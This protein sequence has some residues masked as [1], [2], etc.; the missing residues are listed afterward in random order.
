MFRGMDP[1]TAIPRAI[2]TTC[3]SCPSK[4]LV[5]VLDLGDM[6]LANQL[7]QTGDDPAAQRRYPLEL[8][9]CS[10]CSTIQ[11]AARVAPEKMFSGYCY[12]SSYSDTMVRHAKALAEQVTSRQSLGPESLVIEAGSNDGYL[13]QW[14]RQMGIG[15]LGVEPAAS[16]AHL[17]KTERNI[18]TL[19]AY[20]GE[21]VARE[22]RSE[23]QLADVFH[24][25]NVMAHVP[26]QR[27]FIK[28]I[29][30]VLKENG[31][32]IIEVP[33]VVDM[34]EQLEFD[35]IYHEHVCYFSLSSLSQAFARQ[36]MRVVDVERLPIHGGSLRVTAAHRDS[37]HPTNLRVGRLLAWERTHRVDQFEYYS[38]F[39]GRVCKLREDLRSLLHSLKGQGKRLAAYGA[40]AKGAMLLNHCGIDDSILDFVVD[41]NPIKH[42]CAMPGCQIPIRPT[43]DLLDRMPDFALLLTW[44]FA[45]EI[46][47]QQSEYRRRGGQFIVPVPE[48][49]VVESPNWMA[50]GG[51]RWAS[52]Q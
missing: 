50:R 42:D 17:A 14:Y 8:G 28:G 51:H 32:A 11:I 52:Q 1:A 25:H 33:Y 27:G 34:I 2:R 46:L 20:F 23:G 43:Q 44:N 49:R 4:V 22:L 31:V 5:S 29:A 7:L 19:I 39:A 48:P 15:V 45:E 30:S 47:E 40:S 9:F 10:E 12:Y 38:A 41:R 18:P 35:T 26:N 3:V 6:P 13:L 21:G 36:G 24:A 37:D 16:I